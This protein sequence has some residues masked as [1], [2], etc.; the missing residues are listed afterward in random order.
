MNLLKQLKQL[1]QIFCI[2]YGHLNSFGTWRQIFSEI[3]WFHASKKYSRSLWSES[4]RYANRCVEFKFMNRN[5]FASDLFANIYVAS[6][7]DGSLKKKK[8]DLM[9]SYER[10]FNVMDDKSNFMIHFTMEVVK[11][12][13]FWLIDGTW[14]FLPS[15]STVLII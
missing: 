7:S 10:N 12:F 13:K 5:V 3:Y 15:Y 2:T 9:E 1:T 4:L 11:L 8:N 14:N 6:K